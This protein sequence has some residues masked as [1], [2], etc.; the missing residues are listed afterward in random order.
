MIASCDHLAIQAI[1]QIAQQGKA[2]ID[3]H[4]VNR[5]HRVGGIANFHDLHALGH[6]SLNH[7]TMHASE[8][9]Q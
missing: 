1:E 6:G 8:A 3:Y 7:K 5:H 2:I 9:D 4:I